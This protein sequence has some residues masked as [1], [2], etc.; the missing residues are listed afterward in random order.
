MNASNRQSNIG[1]AERWISLALGTEFLYR[2]LKKRNTSAL[3]AAI[4]GSGLVYRGLMNYCPLYSALGIDRSSRLHGP[5]A[6]VTIIVAKPPAELYRFWRDVQNAPLFMSHVSAVHVL[7]Q[8]HSEWTMT[9]PGGHSFQWTAEITA[10]EP[11][12]GFEWR[13]AK[14]SP[15]SVNGNVRFK[16]AHGCRGTQVIASIRFSRSGGGSLLGKLATPLA[17]YS[18]RNDLA[19][20]KS[21]MEAGEIPTTEGQPSGRVWADRALV[22]SE[23][24]A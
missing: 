6:A 14:G 3:P 19:R 24:P 22:T 15:F 8:T 9:L 16:K 10:D 12:S 1:T 5:D 23:V 13:S 18:V 17:K 7:D 4:I 21:L 11:D 20:F 2:S